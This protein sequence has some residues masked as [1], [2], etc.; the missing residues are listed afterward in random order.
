M[1]PAEE[2]AAMTKALGDDAIAR[3]QRDGYFFPVPVLDAAETAD[4]RA[5][6]EAAE[7][8]EGGALKPVQRNKSHLLFKWL[9]DFIRDPRV[10]DPVE[11]L[12]GPD[13]LCWNTLFWIK[14]AGTATFVSWHQDINYW[15]LEGGEV[16]SAW[17][18]LSPASVEA[19][20]MRVMP[21][22]HLGAV[23]T[24]ED[25]YHADNMLTRGQE[26]AHPLDEAKAVPMPLGPGEMSLHSVRLA[27]ASGANRSAD[28][29]IGLSMH[30]MPTCA[31]QGAG[32]WDSAALVR[33]HDRFGH[34]HHTPRPAADFDPE[35]V[36]FHEQ[37]SAAVRDILY[38][39]AE[40]DTAKL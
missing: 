37:A 25:R 7:A 21:G 20:C 9:D 5:R 14:E 22:T 2:V 1:A 13:I 15:G 17:L 4:L 10:L 36:R 30:F 18:A 31:R 24:H 23:L 35:T 39:G 33:G 11:D 34:F 6:V 3:Y 29:R 8:A 40:H 26:I 38:R 27:H 12:I 19:G 32:D 16:V 28:R